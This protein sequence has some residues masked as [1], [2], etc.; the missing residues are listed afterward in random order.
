MKIAY[1]RPDGGVS[2]VTRLNGDLSLTGRDIPPD[3]TNVRLIDPSDIPADRT[4]RNAWTTIGG[5][6]EHDMEKCR[7]ITK[8]RLRAERAPK[9]AALDVEY[10]RATEEGKPTAAIV[11]QKQVLRDITNL[12]DDAAD[13]EALKALSA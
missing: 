13:L 4:F 1:D 7:E 2:I 5:N 8:E 11:A 6:V 10:I 3:A 12:A 9:L